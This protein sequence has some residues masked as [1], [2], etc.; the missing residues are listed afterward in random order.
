M[1]LQIPCQECNCENTQKS[2]YSIRNQ[3]V[4]HRTRMCPDCHNLIISFQTI[5]V[6][7]GFTCPNCGDS[8]YETDTGISCDCGFSTLDETEGV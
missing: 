5:K 7:L 6:V 3:S 1:K 4:T 2:D 8:M